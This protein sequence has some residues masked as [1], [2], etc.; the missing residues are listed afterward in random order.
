MF[1]KERDILQGISKKLSPDRG[2]LKVIAYGSRIR[3]DFRGDSDLDLLVVVDKKNREIKEKIL[4]IF[5]SYELKTEIS[6]SVT[7]LSRRE[8]EF[9]ER[10]GS[11]FIKE[12]KKEGLILYD[13]ERKREKSALKISY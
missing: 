10:L 7:I 1:K 12:I 5:Y 3:G 11:P 9:N 6:F 4:N 8:L 13:S 2:I